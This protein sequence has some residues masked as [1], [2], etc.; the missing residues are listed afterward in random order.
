MEQL[1]GR[2]FNIQ[3]CSIRDGRG[4]RTTVFFKG[5]GLK[6]LWCA[7]PEGISFK[8]EVSLNPN[9]CMGCGFCLKKCPSQ[10]VYLD[11]AGQMNFDRTKCTGCGTCAALCPTE[12]RK[13]FGEE[14]TVDKL[15]HRIYQD[16]FYFE[17]SGGGVTFSGGE[18]L[19]QPEFLCA[20]SRKCREYKINVAIETCGCG[21]YE[22]FAPCLDY[23][24]FIYFDIKHMDSGMHRKITGQ[25]NEK[26]LKNLEL[27]NEHGIEICI[28]TPV[29]PGWNDSDENIRATAEYISS[30]SSV[31]R[32]ELLAYH[33]L[34]VNKYKILGR[35]YP[36]D[37]VVE[38]AEEHMLHL[39]D[40]ANEVLLKAGKKCFYNKD[41]SA[42]E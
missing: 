6:C 32:Y 28:R 11:D 25:G 24:D 34:G 1:T 29:V 19:M 4:M 38:P 14:Y 22:K 12:A 42:D 9:N 21:D 5:C 15:F 40:V 8:P 41:N 39:V 2:I 27:I 30:L 36:L 10:A 13:L 18:A 26:I 7:N 37:D 3:K 20:I 23:I 33:K 31:R 35:Q 16:R 17:H